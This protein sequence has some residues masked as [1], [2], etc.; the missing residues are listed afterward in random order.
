MLP[1]YANSLL[2]HLEPLVRDLGATE[3]HEGQGTP[4]TVKIGRAHV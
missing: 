3:R 2:E 4:T 1:E